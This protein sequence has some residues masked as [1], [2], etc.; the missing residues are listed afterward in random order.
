MTRKSGMVYDT[1][2]SDLVSF[3]HTQE[4]VMLLSMFKL[5]SIQKTKQK[6]HEL[7]SLLPHKTIMR[8]TSEK[9]DS[10]IL[11]ILY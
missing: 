9:F 2:L 6:V 11:Q 8:T 1:Q 7:L 10:Q 4:T 5:T 3:K